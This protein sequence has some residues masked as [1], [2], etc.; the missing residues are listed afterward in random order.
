[1]GVGTST[2]ATNEQER[3][4]EQEGV[5]LKGGISAPQKKMCP[6]VVC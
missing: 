3:E 4:T 6:G 5:S 2:L 1:M